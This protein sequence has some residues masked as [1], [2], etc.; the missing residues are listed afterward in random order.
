[1]KFTK[2]EKDINEQ[3]IQFTR[4]EMEIIDKLLEES[5]EEQRRNGNKL[6]SHAEVWGQILG[7]ENYRLLH[8]I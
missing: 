1:M 8:R 6:Y 5:D 3:E 2:K 7:E 4:E